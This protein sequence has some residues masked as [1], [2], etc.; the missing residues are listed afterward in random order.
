MLKSIRQISFGIIIGLIVGLWFGV[1]MGKNKPL[2]SNPFAEEDLQQ[3][4][5]LKAEEVIKDTKDAIREKLKE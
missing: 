4:A 5:K 2:F 3:K 1:N